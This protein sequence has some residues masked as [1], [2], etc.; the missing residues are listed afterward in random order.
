MKPPIFDYL[1]PRSLDEA[2]TLLHERRGEARV[3]AGGQSLIPALRLRLTDLPAVID[4][5]RLDGLRDT[6]IDARGWLRVGALTS[7]RSAERSPIV[8]TATPLLA[9]ALP[10]IAHVEIRNQGTIGGSLAHADPAAELPAVA[11]AL[12]ADMV[13][14]SVR[15]EQV[16][17]AEDFF[18]WY[19]STALE[20][21]EILTEIRFPPRN[22][23]E[24]SAVLEVAR[25][26][27]DFALAGMAIRLRRTDGRCDMARV[28]VF[29]V[30]PS[31]TRLAEVE[32]ALVGSTLSD[33]DLREAARAA[34]AAVEPP[35][36]S[37]ASASYRRHATGVLC[38]RALESARSR[39]D[40]ATAVAQA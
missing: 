33:A 23:R 20:E 10:L 19:Y 11:V 14:R 40:D 35:E 21:D 28:V 36:D 34:A 2:V 30:S 39:L 13:S 16:R 25:R 29:A 8:A 38:R 15:G 12:D 3:L 5:G 24:G 6:A 9:E 26:P 7:Q 18:V 1:R 27:G 32:S 17:S 37:Q 4:I 31:P 22:V